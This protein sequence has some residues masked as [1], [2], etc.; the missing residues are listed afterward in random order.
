MG[1]SVNI[2]SSRGAGGSARGRGRGARGRGGR[3]NFK[4]YKNKWRGKK[5]GGSSDFSSPNTSWGG[6][7]ST[8]ST[9]A[10]PAPAPKKP[11]ASSGPSVGLMGPPRQKIVPSFISKSKF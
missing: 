8:P 1:K 6:N 10:K 2:G 5:R 11:V 7:S 3:G 4:N 9:S